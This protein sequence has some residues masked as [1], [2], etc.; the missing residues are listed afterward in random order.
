MESGRTKLKCHAHECKDTASSRLIFELPEYKGCSCFDIMH[1]LVKE[2]PFLNM[3]DGKDTTLIKSHSIFQRLEDAYHEKYGDPVY[4]K[5]QLERT[6][7]N[8]KS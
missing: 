3:A 7:K 8:K 5:A 4:A 2:E 1:K 6:K